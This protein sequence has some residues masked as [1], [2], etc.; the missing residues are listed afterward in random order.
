MLFVLSILQGF[1]LLSVIFFRSQL[2]CNHCTWFSCF[3]MSSLLFHYFL[4][5]GGEAIAGRIKNPRII[6]GTF[7]AG[8]KTQGFAGQL[9]SGQRAS[10]G[11]RAVG[12]TLNVA[13]FF[14]FLEISKWCQFSWILHPL[15][16]LWKTQCFNQPFNTI[17]V[18]TTHG[19][20]FGWLLN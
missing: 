11:Q 17:I 18:T 16:D 14:P 5:F 1:L 10:I 19:S 15:D 13:F 2:F 8:K 7:H 20:F 12:L 9:A 4:L 3:Q 6:V